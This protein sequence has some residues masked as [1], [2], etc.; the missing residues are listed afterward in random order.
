MDRIDKQIEKFEESI[1]R[2]MSRF[3]LFIQKDR[4]FRVIL[5]GFFII[6]GISVNLY[7]MRYEFGE[8]L[9]T[10]QRFLL[11]L[12]TWGLFGL[13][14]FFDE[15]QRAKEKTTSGKVDALEIKVDGTNTKLDTLIANIDT[16]INEI[17]QER[18]ERKDKP[19]Q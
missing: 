2:F 16:L 12:M 14:I 11:I 8:V 1:N 4:R 17:R 19:K 7:V 13:I 15:L 3:N 5:K 10:D 18:N 6:V 9:F